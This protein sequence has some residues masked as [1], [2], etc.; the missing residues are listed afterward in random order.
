MSASFR[1][2]RW[3]A[4]YGVVLMLPLPGC[5]VGPEESEEPVVSPS[6]VAPPSS[7]EEK[8]YRPAWEVFHDNE[9]P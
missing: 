7:A 8:P 4:I 3:V 9:G 2:L 6:R 5:S 1:C